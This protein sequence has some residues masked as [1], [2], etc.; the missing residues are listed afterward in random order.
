M[1]IYMYIKQF[2]KLGPKSKYNRAKKKRK[3]VYELYPKH[4]QFLDDDKS[5]CIVSKCISIRMKEVLSMHKHV[6][7]MTSHL[8]VK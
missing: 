7:H 3:S 5:T 2:D 4:I 8:G 6:Y 1:T